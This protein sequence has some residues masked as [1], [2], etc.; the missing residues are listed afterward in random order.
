MRQLLVLIAAAASVFGGT[1][2]FASRDEEP[3]PTPAAAP[4]TSVAAAPAEAP[5]LAAPVA[6][7]SAAQPEIASDAS[8]PLARLVAD[9]NSGDAAKRA[10]AIVGLT[11]ASRADA[12]PVLRNVLLNGE[13][14]VDRPLALRSLREIALAQGDADGAIREAVRAVIYHG[15][16]AAPAEAAQETLDAI[17]ASQLPS[18]SQR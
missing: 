4:A 8:V 14:G 15:D 3:V 10:T 11:R 13:P 9:V 6:P 12:I 5:S 16:D 17:E 1:Y 7:P 18:V 2:W